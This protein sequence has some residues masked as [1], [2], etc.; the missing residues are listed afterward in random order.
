[1]QL[2]SDRHGWRECRG[3]RSKS[4]AGRHWEAVAAEHLERHGLEVLTRGYRCRLGELDLVCRDG[5]MLVVVEVRAR[6]TTSFGSAVTTIGPHKRRRII[7]A[8]RHLLMRH[9]ELAAAKIRFDVVTFD[10][11]DTPEPVVH[12]IKN[13]FDGS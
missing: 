9:R 2:Q 10:S 5:G 6:G 13:A 4:A 1:M 11:I 7:Q 12:W 3:R 8:T